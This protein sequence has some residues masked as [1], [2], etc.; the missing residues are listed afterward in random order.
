MCE[1]HHTT[2]DR[3]RIQCET[4]S[5]ELGL[6][7]GRDRNRLNA[8]GQSRI[9]TLYERPDRRVPVPD[10]L[11]RRGSEE[12]SELPADERRT[13]DRTFEIAF[14]R[15]EEAELVGDTKGLAQIGFVGDC[16]RGVPPTRTSSRLHHYR[17]VY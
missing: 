5:C 3:Y 7:L 8:F 10:H 2:L 15:D 14:D 12:A 11:W 6:V 16:G 1:R 9:T 13:T 17:A 4:L